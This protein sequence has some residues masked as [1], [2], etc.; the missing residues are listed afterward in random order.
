MN[1]LIL[2]VSVGFDGALQRPLR[3][4]CD[5][6]WSGDALELH[7]NSTALVAELELAHLYSPTNPW[8]TEEL[9]VRLLQMDSCGL[10]KL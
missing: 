8:I 9:V 4:R 1:I 3:L 7:G 10:E 2:A 6:M 5:A